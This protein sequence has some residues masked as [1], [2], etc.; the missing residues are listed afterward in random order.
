MPG[1]E[2]RHADVSPKGPDVC[3]KS[4]MMPLSPRRGRCRRNHGRRNS[5][6]MDRRRNRR[7]NLR[8]LRPVG[9]SS[10]PH[11]SGRGAGRPSRRSI[12]FASS[13]P[14]MYACSPESS[15]GAGR[16][17]TTPRV[18]P[19]RY[20]PGRFEMEYAVAVSP[21]RADASSYRSVVESGN[22]H[23]R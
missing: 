5:K 3:G 8:V 13:S 20:W 7:R 17:M 10:R 4:G 6:I 11:L 18:V 19:P 9:C 14:S 2:S 1:G 15:P 22:R 16:K 12:D 23:R 21:A